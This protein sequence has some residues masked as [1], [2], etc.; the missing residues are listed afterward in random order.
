MKTLVWRSEEPTRVNATREYVAYA[1]HEGLTLTFEAY[2]I[3]GAWRVCIK[4]WSTHDPE[5]RHR[6]FPELE[7]AKAFCEKWL[8]DPALR[9]EIKR[10]RQKAYTTGAF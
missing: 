4:G 2:E 7:D 5:G 10:N 1:L 6:T 8:V 3:L 9:A